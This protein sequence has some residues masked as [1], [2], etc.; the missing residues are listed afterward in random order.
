LDKLPYIGKAAAAG[1]GTADYQ[2][3]NPV[4]ASI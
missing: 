4:T 3:L 1:L 2:K